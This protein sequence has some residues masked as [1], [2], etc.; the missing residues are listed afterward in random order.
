MSTENNLVIETTERDFVMSRVF[1]APREKV[2]RAWTAPDLLAKWW[3]PHGFTNPVCKINLKPGGAYRIV[4][5]SPDGSEYP[6]TGVYEEIVAPEL[7]VFT[8]NWEEHPAEWTE[9]LKRNLRKGETVSAKEALNTVTFEDE[10][11][12]TKLT[13]RTRFESA[14]V[15]DAMV[16]MGMPDGWNQ[17]LDRLAT[18]L[19]S[20]P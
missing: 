10:N 19:A 17:S 15:R 7:L 13:L 1:D 20:M 16:K 18:L 6:L 2:F 5:R 12:K 4:M 3:G 11:G 14:A 9:M 8:D